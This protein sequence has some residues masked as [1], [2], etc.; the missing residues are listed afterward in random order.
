MTTRREISEW[1]RPLIALHPTMV[2]ERHLLIFR[3]VGHI[4]RCIAFWGSS[5]R[6]SPHPDWVLS[7]LFFAPSLINTFGRDIAIGHSN[8]PGFR[9]LFEERA[10]ESIVRYLLPHE[11]IEDFHVRAR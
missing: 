11:T 1:V 8:W 4:L 3:P 6:F 5:N 9:E 2:Q 10:N 7:P